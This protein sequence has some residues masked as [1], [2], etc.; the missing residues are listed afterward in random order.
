MKLLAIDP[1]ETVGLAFLD[2]EGGKVILLGSLEVP[3]PKLKRHLPILLAGVDAVVIEDYRIFAS[4]AG[5]HVGTRL[6]TSELIGFIEAHCD[7]KSILFT[8]LQPNEKGR[9]PE[10]RMR[11][12]HPECRDLG[13]HARDALKIG[14]VYIEKGGKD[15]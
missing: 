3:A 9:W 12:K 10:A 5:H 6:V 2:T 13:G 4:H 1:G 8:R 11:A 7:L 15:V 14:L